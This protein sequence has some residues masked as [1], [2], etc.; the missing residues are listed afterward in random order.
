M[1]RRPKRTWFYEGFFI[2]QQQATLLT[3][4]VSAELRLKDIA[5]FI[6]RKGRWHEDVLVGVTV[7]RPR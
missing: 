6:Q 5:Q 1:D 3:G 7:V 4:L 2:R